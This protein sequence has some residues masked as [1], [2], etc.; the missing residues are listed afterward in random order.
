[1]LAQQV[2]LA[3]AG[4][5]R[6]INI[7]LA[8]KSPRRKDLLENW[9][10]K[11]TIIEPGEEED[12]YN[13]SIYENVII[14]AR[15]K[16]LNA[17]IENTFNGIILGG[18]T[19]IKSPSGEIIGKPKNRKDAERILKSLSSGT[20]EVVSGIWAKKVPGVHPGMGGID[21]ALVT[22]K[23]IE[24]EMLENYLNSGLWKGKAG[25]YGVQDPQFPFL[26]KVEGE[27]ETVIGLPKSITLAILNALNK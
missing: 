11:P 16:C 3:R 12:S 14:K 1:M 13:I 26:D 8:S 6:R 18:D 4:M 20:H 9:G 10:F 23:K 2:E 24:D 19:A 25:G 27:I 17:K 15:A 22:F 5:R 7:Y 21:I